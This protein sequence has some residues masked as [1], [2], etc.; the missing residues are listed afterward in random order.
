MTLRRLPAALVVVVGLVVLVLVGSSRQAPATAQFTSLGVPSTPFVPQLDFITSSWFCPGAPIGGDGHGGTVVITNPGDTPLIGQVT[1]FTDAADQ[2]PIAEP[3]QVPPRETTKVDLATVQ[4]RGTYVAGLVEITGGG[5]FVEQ[6]ARDPLGQAVAPCA[7]STS[8]DWYFPDGYTKDA[9]TEDIV[10]TNPF[11]DDAIVN[12]EIA[13]AQGNRSPAALQGY[14]VRGHSVS[15]VKIDSIVR[16]DAVLAVGVHSSRG[17]I[18][19]GRAQRFPRGA[20]TGFTMNLGA[21]ALT[22][23]A[24]F[25]DGEQG[26]GISERFSIYN[27]SANDVVVQAVFL[28]VP[29]DAAFAND[30]QLTVPAGSV[31]TLDTADVAGLPAGRHGVVFDHRRAVDRRRARLDP[32]CRRR[33]RHDGRAR[34]AA[35]GGGDP[36]EHGRRLRPPGRRRPRRAQRRQRELAGHGEGARARR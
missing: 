5:G 4:P 9:S 7:N 23:Q 29:I 35:A 2:S 27:G 19:A 18:V 25:A 16:D 28:G 6:I 26:S 17:R 1:A 13:T 30:T 14:P 21:P 22:D 20:R 24:W 3:F 12:F 34:S 32:S 36:V 11:P 33:H 8:N 31:A 10:I 15:I